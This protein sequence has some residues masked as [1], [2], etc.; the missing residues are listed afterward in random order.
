MQEISDECYYLLQK[1]FKNL[2]NIG[3]DAGRI[4]LKLMNILE[5]FGHLNS[6]LLEN[7]KSSSVEE[8]FQ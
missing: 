7:S 4:I 2:T 6:H 3:L 1:F 5:D 8:E